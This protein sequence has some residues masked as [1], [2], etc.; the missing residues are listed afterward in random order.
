MVVANGDQRVEAVAHR[1]RQTLRH[2]L[3]QQG[4]GLVPGRPHRT[5]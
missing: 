4:A 2:A 3:R 5:A 1:R